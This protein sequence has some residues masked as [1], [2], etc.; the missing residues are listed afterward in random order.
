MDLGFAVIG[1]LARH[2]R[3]HIRFLFIGSRLGSTLL[4][5]P[6]S[7]RVLFSPLRFANPSS[8]SDWV[9]DLH[10]QAVVHAR[11]TMKKRPLNLRAFFFFVIPGGYSAAKI[12]RRRV[13]AKAN[14][15]VPN[16]ASVEGSGTAAAT[17]VS[18]P[19]IVVDPLKY[20][21]PVLIVN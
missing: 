14:A 18:P 11:H 4:S 20:P 21:S 15:P 9:E 2:R 3:P 17:V 1:P 8:P 5:G 19:E 12:L 6:T 16:R 10:L 7:R 13:P